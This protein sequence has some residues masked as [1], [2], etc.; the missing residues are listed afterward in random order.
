[1]TLKLC[2]TLLHFPK[3][4]YRKKIMIAIYFYVRAPLR[5]VMLLSGGKISRRRGSGRRKG[6]KEVSGKR[7][8]ALQ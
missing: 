6:R 4:K 8:L 2:E 3:K 7:N 1:M 5:E